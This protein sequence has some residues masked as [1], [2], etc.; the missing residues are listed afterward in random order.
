[1]STGGSIFY[2]V[3]LLLVLAIV[4]GLLLYYAMDMRQTVD[5]AQQAEQVCRQELAQL[6]S[7]LETGRN[8]I[9]RLQEQNQ[10]LEGQLGQLS[11]SHEAERL[12]RLQAEAEASAWRQRSQQLEQQI[13]SNQV[14]HDITTNEIQN[15][16]TQLEQ[17]NQGLL[18]AQAQ[19][20]ALRQQLQALE[21]TS[22][23][24]QL[25]GNWL[26]WGA[27]EKVILGLATGGLATS[28][29]ATAALALYSKRRRGW[30]SGLNQ[31][32][33]PTPSPIRR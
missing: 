18:A 10:T 24:L 32:R 23:L 21:Q 29:L 22:A 14:V 9:Q 13:T 7:E 15:L 4:L 16:A 30:K 3:L 20:Q 5:L 11:Q 1:M 2:T 31:A 26:E 28:G 25:L 17:A 19:N 8:E 6:S 33:L 27:Q 12:G